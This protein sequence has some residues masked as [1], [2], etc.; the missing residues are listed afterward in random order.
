MPTKRS[1]IQ[2]SLGELISALRR[3]DPDA[4]VMF[5]FVH[6]S[7]SGGVHSYRGYYEDL[8]IGY[9]VGSDTKVSDLLGWLEK[10]VGETFYGYKG[11]SYTMGDDTPVWVANSNE[12]GSTVIVDVVDE[13]W[14]VLLKTASIDD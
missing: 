4:I 11:G 14:R 10:A 12:T 3:K 6:F 13:G 1:D 5:D 9:A 8:A 7:P 2:M